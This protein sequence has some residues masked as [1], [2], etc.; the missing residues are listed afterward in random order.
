MPLSLILAGPER[1]TRDLA[2]HLAAA[3]AWPVRTVE[4]F[5]EA[6]RVAE[7]LPYA[8]IIRHA[9]QRGEEP[10]AWSRRADP[11][12]RVPVVAWV[13]DTD[14]VPAD[15]RREEG[16]EAIW[17]TSE[18][19]PALIELVR[20]VA[21]RHHAHL[22]EDAERLRRA[23]G[24]AGAGYYLYDI[25]HDK[26]WWD[27]RA[28][29]IF[30]MDPDHRGINRRLWFQ[31]LHEEDRRF[32]KTAFRKALLSGEPFNI[33]YRIVRTDGSVR[34]VWTSGIIE[35]DEHGRPRW[36]QGLLF[37]ATEWQ[38]Q[39][40]REAVFGKVVEEAL[41]EV[42]LIDGETLRFLQVNR[43]AR[44]NLGYDMN[45]LRSMTPMDLRPGRSRDGLMGLFAPLRDGRQDTIKFSSWHQ[46]KDGT[47]YPTEIEI[48]RSFLDDREVFIAFV[49]DRTRQA[50]TD[51]TLRRLA[52]VAKETDNAVV[53]TDPA[54]RI[55]WVNEGFT[56]MT[57]YTLA[58]VAGRK[59]GAILQGPGTDPSTKAR[60]REAIAK[61]ETV[62]VEILNYRKNGQAFWSELSIQPV[63]DEDGQLDCFISLS[64][65]VTERR[66]AER[67]LARK[68]AAVEAFAYR[69]RRLHRLQTTTY[70]DFRDM[71]EAYLRAGC[72][73]FG[74]ETG[75]VSRIDGDA[76]RVCHVVTPLEGLAA[77]QVFAVGDTYCE[78][79]YRE[80]RTV[81]YE[82]VGAREGLRRHPVYESLRLEAYL[83]TPVW[84]HGRLW[85]TLNFSSVTPRVLP[86]SSHDRELIE[87]M[88]RSIGRFLEVMEAEEARRQSTEELDTFFNVSPEMLAIMTPRGRLRRFN[89]AWTACLGYPRGVLRRRSIMN[90]LLPEDRKAMQV[91]L[92]QLKGKQGP[93]RLEVR[94]WHREGT[95]R[96]LTWSGVWEPDRA[97]V[98]V[99]VR[100]VT[101]QRAAEEAVRTSERRYQALAAI[102][103]VGIFRTDAEGR[104]V[105]VNPRWCELT[106]LEPAEAMG[107]GWQRAVH[108]ED[109]DRIVDVWE[110]A[111]A[112]RQEFRM[113][114]RF[115]QP[116]GREVWVYGQASPERDEEGRV[117]GFV[118][119]VTDITDQKQ[120][121]RI[122]R[123]HS[124]LL[125]SMRE[126]VAL[127]DEAGLVVYTNPSCEAMFGYAG[128]DLA[129]MTLPSL[130]ARPGEADADLMEVI[131]ERL[132][133][134]GYW[135]GPLI[136]QRA[137]GSLFDVDL[138][139]SLVE[140]GAF[141]FWLCVMQDVTE[142]KKM[143]DLLRETQ[144][145]A[146]V[147][148]WEVDLVTERLFW[149]D[150]VYRIHD[151]P[152]GSPV[153]VEK[154]I[155]F[156]V[157][158]DRERIRRA[159]E[160]GSKTGEGWDLECRILTAM[161]RER[162][163]R[164]IG[165]VHLREGTPYRLSGTFQDITALKKVERLK[166]EFISIVS[167]ELRTPLTSISG[168]LGLVAGGVA[169]PLPEPA[170]NMVEIARRNAD[171]L[172]RLINDLLD[173]QK[174]EAGKLTLHRQPLDLGEL[175][176]QSLD[177]N[178]PYAERFGVTF[179]FEGPRD[180]LPV[181]GD[182]DRLHQVM[183]NL[184]S[185]AA[186]FSPR[187]AEV[188]V[189]VDR[190]G[191]NARVAVTDR[192]PGIPAAF[193]DKIFGKFEQADASVRRKQEGTGLGLNITKSIVDMHG[194]H[195]G[196]ETEEGQG[197]TFFFELPLDGGRIPDVPDR[198]RIQGRRTG[199]PEG[200]TPAVRSPQ[201]A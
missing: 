36:L 81:G 100:D 179:V 23:V 82:Q 122:H 96:W 125:E 185:N 194:G 93:D 72:E 47:R 135:R 193:R 24:A 161:G 39:A 14:A 149:T 53:V 71:A 189:S 65:D 177:V 55:L 12:T 86:F 56:R 120:A 111:T 148:G 70:A 139:V 163:V 183:T 186:K 156:Y 138:H 34:H 178:R 158:E 103:P 132:V 31:H 165:R 7:A 144:A 106:G 136:G 16:E 85:G 119:T 91:W 45:E 76:Y 33:T 94:A 25:L 90:L 49:L 88:A 35:R 10:A 57:G 182:N 75:I 99:V 192:G 58:E 54:L 69:L 27:E 121:E 195:I 157:P 124:R 64:M 77:G 155:S 123:I 22:R 199:D 172:V 131:Q 101:E 147:G 198:H 5:E 13:E 41:H 107:W 175:V 66:Q 141:S 17:R 159:V 113:E 112:S 11:G 102:A 191:E 68:H 140:I 67:E 116:G 160:R 74:M 44:E 152:V 190:V 146:A 154:A 98:F 200:S 26:G 6:Y 134:N 62:N 128:G 9:S 153:D 73:M 79:V 52:L 3:S 83:G 126:G 1:A 50:E 129:G 60:I 63:F 137:D 2:E 40:E 29:E 108:P 46:R 105:Y 168:S 176:R 180:P 32:L 80:E 118:G 127:V 37:D 104:C 151:L 133:A 109:R 110:E 166:D 130:L 61:R 173:V 196:F 143:Y 197:T 170:R 187:G 174:I 19:V 142:Q 114:Y 150:E 162:W 87:M 38:R 15:P 184:L 48:R 188:R 89:A 167:H 8:L 115:V 117:L 51:Q 169:G 97:E 92:G 21:I 78:A 181:R 59:P 4:T 84:V 28:C 171:R 95:I 164:A 42:Y 201:E 30:G 145:M 20:R 18:G 43:R